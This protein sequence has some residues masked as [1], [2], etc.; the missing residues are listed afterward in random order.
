MAYGACVSGK[1][2]QSIFSVFPERSVG[3]WTLNLHLSSCPQKQSLGAAQAVDIFAMKAQRRGM[4]IYFNEF[5][6]STLFFFF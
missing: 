3:L 1:S 6:V 4:E 2:L 5:T